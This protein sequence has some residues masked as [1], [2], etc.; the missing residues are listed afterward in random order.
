MH[1]AARPRE[2]AA[3]HA[4]S[5]RLAGTSVQ[6]CHTTLAQPCRGTALQ[7]LVV[8][9]PS[10]LHQ[11]SISQHESHSQA[12]GHTDCRS[13]A[14][15][16]RHTA[17]PLSNPSVEASPPPPGHPTHMSSSPAACKASAHPKPWS[18]AIGLFHEVS[19]GLR[20][21]LTAVRA[22]ARAWRDGHRS[23]VDRW[24]CQAASLGNSLI[25]LPCCKALLVHSTPDCCAAACVGMGG[26]QLAWAAARAA[27]WH[28]VLGH[29]ADCGR[30]LR[31]LASWGG[32]HRPHAWLSS[33]VHRPGKC[34]KQALPWMPVPAGT[35]DW[36][37]HR[38][39]W[40]RDKCPVVT[41]RAAASLAP[42][43]PPNCQNYT[44]KINDR[45]RSRQPKDGRACAGRDDIFSPLHDDDKRHNRLLPVHSPSFSFFPNMHPAA[46]Q[47]VGSV[48]CWLLVGTLAFSAPAARPEAPLVCSSAQASY[49][50]WAARPPPGRAAASLGWAAAAAAAA[51]VRVQWTPLLVASLALHAC[52]SA[53]PPF[54]PPTPTH[55]HTHTSSQPIV[56]DAGTPTCGIMQRP[57]GEQL[58]SGRHCLP[59]RRRRRGG[60]RPLAPAAALL[61]ASAT[62]AAAGAAAGR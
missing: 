5:H 22:R 44:V 18:I 36:R 3:P 19:C 27:A 34:F 47:L 46:A 62:T 13:A 26:A 40:N 37:L 2:A 61:A 54:P 43:P 48:W 35:Q 6:C 23:R 57:A 20:P 32:L 15:W 11:A 1:E 50:K 60:H 31:L 10:P 58:S 24:C 7:G 41:T 33:A 52:T 30:T 21:G 12:P 59:S 38:R 39:A 16:P 51:V 56:P 45:E 17:L 25:C 49:G 8:K 9:Y 4:P 55:T 29:L 42:P 28:V 53:L 14:P